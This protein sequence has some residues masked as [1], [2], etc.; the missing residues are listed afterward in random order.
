MELSQGNLDAMPP[1]LQ[2]A[3]EKALHEHGLAE[4][5]LDPIR[6]GRAPGL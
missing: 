6:L 5:Q 3:I 2:E 4:Y 1:H